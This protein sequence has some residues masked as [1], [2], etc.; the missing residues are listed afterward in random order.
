MSQKFIFAG[1]GTAGH[2]VPA[3]AVAE[4]LVKNG[5]DPE[6]IG[7]VGVKR[8]VESKIVPEYGFSIRTLPGRGLRRNLSISSILWNALAVVQFAFATIETFASFLSDRPSAVVV[9]GGYGAAPSA[10]AAIV[11]RLPLFVTQVD[12]HPGTVNKFASRFA[13][14]VAVPSEEISMPNRVVTGVP[15]RESVR[16]VKFT[17]TARS[18][19][20]KALGVP[21]DRKLIVVMGGSLGSQSINDATS[22]LV[23]TWSKRKDLAVL[24]ITGL[25]QENKTVQ[26]TKDELFYHAIPYSNDIET[27]YSAADVFVARAGANSVAELTAVGIP[28]IFIPLPIAPGDHQRKNAASVANAGGAVIIDDAECTGERLAKELDRILSDEVYE[29]MRAALRGIK[30]PA[31]AETIADLVRSA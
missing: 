19:A 30:K 6:D 21:A 1:G 27:I 28:S 7:F 22:A 3:V 11:L 8:G 5:V 13:K 26:D 24:H 15:I 29:N 14:A 4:A 18:K 20:R 31:A 25:K 9:V 2:V 12:S 10:V 16:S 17:A 23:K